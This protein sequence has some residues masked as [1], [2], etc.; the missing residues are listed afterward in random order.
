[1]KRRAFPQRRARLACGVVGLCAA[2]LPARA[3]AAPPKIQ[4]NN[5][6]VEFFQ[7]PVIAPV[8]ITGLAG[9]YAGYAEGVEGTATNAAAPAVREPFSVRA[10]DWDLTASF[11]F[12]GSYASTDFDNHG[13]ASSNTPSSSFS[14]FLYL[15]VGAQ[16]QYDLFGASITGDLQHFNLSTPTTQSSLTLQIGRFH[17]LGAYGVFNDQLVIGAGVRILAL[18]VNGNNNVLGNTGVFGGSILTMT[19]AAPELGALLKPDGA[20]WRLGA[21]VR[22]PVTAGNVGSAQTTTDAANVT[23]VGEFIVPQSIV[24]PWE[25][26]IGLALQAG[27]RPL[28]PTWLNPE[29]EEAPIRLQISRARATRAAR[30]AEILRNTA[31]VFAAA[32]KGELAKEEA[33]IQGIENQHLDIESKKLLAQRRARYANWPR[34]KLLFVA[35]AVITGPDSNTVAVESFLEQTNEPFGRY[36]TVTPRFGV[37]SEPVIDWVRLRAGTYIEPSRFENGT[38]RDHFTAGADFKLFPF[39]AFGL[40]DNTTWRASFAVDAAPRYFNWG[41]GIGLWH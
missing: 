22:A 24:Q 14:N 25:L 38:A 30:Y 2:L 1:L 35:S 19:G 8:R 32:E 41:L 3:F 15:N 5:Y 37:E 10:L 33:A 7:G 28:N 40:L 36:V 13:P 18:N 29:Q 21:T 16:I 9:A 6:K 17:A 31:P 34:E 20:F 12:P 4:D 23:R 26:E 39:N 11:S 27:P